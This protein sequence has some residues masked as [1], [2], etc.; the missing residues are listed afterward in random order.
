MDMTN[1]M[2]FLTMLITFI[3]GI[4]AKKHPSF[5]NKKIPVQNLIIGV[6]GAVVN[7]IFTKDFNMALAFSGLMTGGVYDL[8]KNLNDLFKGGK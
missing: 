2:T 5:D 8:V 6:A 3:C 4:I 1:I 7:F